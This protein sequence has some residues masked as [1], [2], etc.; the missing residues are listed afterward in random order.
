MSES[1]VWT[2]GEIGR[3]LHT[4]QLDTELVVKALGISRDDADRLK[5]GDV[6]TPDETVRRYDHAALL[7][8]VLVRLEL[9]CGHDTAALHAALERSVDTLAGDSI[10]GWLR[11]DVDLAG[12]RLL[13]EVAG[14]VP[15]LKVKMWRVADR[16]S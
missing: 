12:L 7:L 2:L 8:N 14:T 4:H 1:L 5:R 11:T 6:G 15:V 9:R 10:A 16:Y 3:L 13:R